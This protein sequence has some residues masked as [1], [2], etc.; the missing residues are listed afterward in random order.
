MLLAAGGSLLSYPLIT[1]L[2]VIAGDVLG[3][4]A[5]GYSQLLS[6][7][8]TGAI[9]GALLTA[10]RGKAPARGRLLLLGFLLYGVATLLAVLLRSQLAAMLLLFVAGT[11]LVTSFS[12][13]NSLMQEAAP[14][15]FRGRVVSIYGLFFRGGMPVGS[16]VAGF[17]VHDF[18]AASTLA[19]SSGLTIV[20]A[21]AA[22]LSSRR[23]REL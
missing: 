6:S 23:L 3:T 2:P 5:R 7:F 12:I 10:Q 13:L 8:G 16:L 11:S 18:G 22:A 14:D 21:V 1:Y 17:F 4:G 9:L 19:V 15:A 20:L